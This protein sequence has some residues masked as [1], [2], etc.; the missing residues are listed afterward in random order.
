[1]TPTS[2]TLVTDTLDG[3]AVGFLWTREGLGPALL[4]RYS[5]ELGGKAT[6]RREPSREGAV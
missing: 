2:T 6:G 5:S 1:M 3:L 4:R